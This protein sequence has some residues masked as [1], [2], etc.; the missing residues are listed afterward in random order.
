MKSTFTRGSS[1]RQGGFTILEIIIMVTVLG[2]VAAITVPKFKTMLYQ[3]R[4]GRTKTNLGDVRGALAIYYSDNF[5]LYPS[6][7]GTPE[8]RLSSVLV[9]KY[10]K[11]M[12]VTDLKH[13]HP[14]K[15]STVQDTLDDQGDWVYSLLNGFVGVNCTHMDTKGLPVSSW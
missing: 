2:I 11:T 4:E 6:E 9:P 5:G 8:T 12:P 15:K 13:F 1:D 10:L 14:A 3:S 7:L